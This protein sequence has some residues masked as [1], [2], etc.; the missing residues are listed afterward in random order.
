MAPVRRLVIDVLKPHDPPL[1]EFTDHVA[2]IE[3]V[4]AVTASLI[5]LDKEVQN[6]KLTFEGADVDFA[7]IEETVENLG[8]A[9]HSIDQVSSGEHIVTDRVTFQD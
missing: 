2:E 6:V 8:G 9:V 7:A 4:E 5:E 1:I 3:S